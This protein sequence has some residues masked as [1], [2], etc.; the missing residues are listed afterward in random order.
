MDHKD[1]QNN[2]VPGQGK[3]LNLDQLKKLAAGQ[4]IAPA[5]AATAKPRRFRRGQQAWTGAVAVGA[6]LAAAGALMIRKGDVLDSLVRLPAAPAG[7]D[8]G[9]SPEEQERY[10]AMAS[11]EPSGF[12]GLLGVKKDDAARMEENARKLQRLLSDEETG[13]Q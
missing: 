8:V 1:N 2:L 3:P 13:L 5:R 10:W 12:P 7:P 6:L 11:Y 4:S 9:M